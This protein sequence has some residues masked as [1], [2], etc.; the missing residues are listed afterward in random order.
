MQEDVESHGDYIAQ[1]LRIPYML[2]KG[3]IAACL[4]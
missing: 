3:G 4:S 1:L 2:E